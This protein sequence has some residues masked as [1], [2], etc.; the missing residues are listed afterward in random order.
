MATKAELQAELAELKRLFAESRNAGTGTPADTV[1]DGTAP[2]EDDSDTVP[3]NVMSEAMAA[4]KGSDL[5]DMAK[6]IMKELE[7]LP[8]KKPLLTALGAFVLGYL[9]GRAR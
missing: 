3:D 6:Q 8:E 1:N 5:E 4:L 9:I 7:S 2:D